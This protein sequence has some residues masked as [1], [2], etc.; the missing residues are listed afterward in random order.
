MKWLTTPAKWVWAQLSR[1]ARSN[2]AEVLEAAALAAR[3]IVPEIAEMLTRRDL[4]GD[5]R[6]GAIDEIL[7]ASEEFAPLARRF[8]GDAGRAL[9]ALLP[10]QDLAHWLA[11]ARVYAS[12]TA[13]L[14]LD[15]LPRYRV[16]MGVLSAVLSE[17]E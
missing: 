1:F 14:G 13:T 15:R 5:G 2:E 17:V 8:S 11:T 12:L 16:L 9:L 10:S 7:Q 4:D 6:I 3:R